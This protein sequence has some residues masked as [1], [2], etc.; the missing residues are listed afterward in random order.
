MPDE[1]GLTVPGDATSAT[2][3]DFNHD[4]RPDLAVAQND[5]PLLTFEST[6]RGAGKFLKLALDGDDG[7]SSAVG[8]RVTALVKS[9]KKIVQEVSDGSGYL[10]QSSSHPILALGDEIVTKIIV[11]WPDGQVSETMEVPGKGGSLR[12]AAP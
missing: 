10:S 4:G 9:G 2:V 3:T 8:A 5:G 7:N 11:R 12:I 6:G 1:S